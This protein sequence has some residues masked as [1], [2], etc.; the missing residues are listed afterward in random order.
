MYS[1]DLTAISLDAFEQTI[2]TTDLL[3]SRKMLAERI[4]DVLQELKRTGFNNLEDL[5][6]LLRD[7]GRYAEIAASLSV[8]EKYLIVLNRGVNSYVSKPVPLSQ[9]GVFE[10]PELERL[11]LARIRSTKDLYERCA[12]PADRRSI[13]IEHDLDDERLAQALEL[14]DL[15]R[16]N[17]VGPA[18]AH[19]L[20]DVGIRSPSDFN[21][22]APL[23]I[24]ECYR[25]SVGDGAASGPELRLEDLEYCRRF[26]LRLSYDI[27]R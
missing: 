11:R 7:K 21:S 23:E 26:S 12:L 8:D 17:G 27:E 18:F 20:S 22:T 24:L 1:T 6:V 16:I 19:F 10:Q 14:S 13:A 25:Q 5:R 15:V 3:P 9:L 4:S 2:L